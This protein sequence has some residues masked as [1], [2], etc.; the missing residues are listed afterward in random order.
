MHNVEVGKK[1]KCSK[2]GSTIFFIKGVDITHDYD[3]GHCTYKEV[4]EN[5]MNGSYDNYDYFKSY[6]EV[7]CSNCDDIVIEL[8]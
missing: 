3:F 2:C 8:S 5:L 7:R 6:S 1:M 4:E